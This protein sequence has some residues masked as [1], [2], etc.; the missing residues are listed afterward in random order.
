LNHSMDFIFIVNA[1]GNVVNANLA[2]YRVLGNSLDNRLNIKDFVKDSLETPFSIPQNWFREI[3]S[4]TTDLKPASYFNML[5]IPPGTHKRI[6]ID[7]NISHASV[8]G[9]SLALIIARDMT[10]QRNQE[11]QKEQLQEQLFHSQRLESLGLL[12]GGVAHDFNNMLHTIQCS[13]EALKNS[14]LDDSARDMV[15]NID[16]ATTRAS[17]LTSQLLGF[18][19]KGNYCPAPI[20]ISTMLQQVSNLFKTTLRGVTF[21]DLVEPGLLPIRADSTQLQQVILNLLINARDAIEEHHV[22]N[23]KIVLRGERV[24]ANTPEWQAGLQKEK[25]ERE[26]DPDWKKRLPK[27]GLHPDDYVCIK[28]KDNGCGIPPDALGHIFEP[29]YTTKKQG[30]GTGM[31]LAMA[32]GCIENLKGWIH[33]ESKLGQGT[34][35]SIVLPVANAPVNNETQKS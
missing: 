21:K 26:K 7:F 17:V 4:D 15:S 24:R 33:V 11:K 32:Y 30:K 10:E 35:F 27:A 9:E 29:F 16:A 22:D 25:N 34:E 3:L 12:A 20:E 18:A 13:A 28:V 8:E 2:L 23:P 31:G 14:R 19:R 1:K 6:N 5:L